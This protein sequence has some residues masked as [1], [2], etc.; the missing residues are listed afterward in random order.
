MS[1]NTVSILSKQKKA[2]FI[3]AGLW[4]SPFLVDGSQFILLAGDAIMLVSYGHFSFTGTDGSY[5]PPS[6]FHVDQHDFIDCSSKP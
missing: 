2:L 1:L 4:P 3:A 5:Y 6:L